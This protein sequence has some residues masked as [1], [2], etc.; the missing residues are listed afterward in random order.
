MVAAALCGVGAIGWFL[1]NPDSNK[2][3]VS[4]AG[5]TTA[6]ATAGTPA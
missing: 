4:T 1:V 3:A 6:N 5:A 2:V